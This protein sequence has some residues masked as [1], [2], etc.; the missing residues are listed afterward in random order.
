[1]H[2]SLRICRKILR[3][4]ALAF[5]FLLHLNVPFV[6]NSLIVP[7]VLVVLPSCCVITGFSTLLGTVSS[8]SSMLTSV[9]IATCSSVVL[10]TLIGHVPSSRFYQTVSR[11]VYSLRCVYRSVFISRMIYSSFHVRSSLNRRV[12]L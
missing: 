7:Y 3:K 4:F 10:I 6:L 5:S 2:R 1:M 12:S 9:G 11:T 8:I